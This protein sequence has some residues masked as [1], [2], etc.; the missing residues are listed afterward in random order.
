[1]EEEAVKNNPVL[2]ILIEFFK[3]VYHGDE[4]KVVGAINVIA[5]QVQQEGCKLIHFGNVVFLVHVTGSHMVEFHAMVGGKTNEKQK[6]AEIDKQL[7]KLLPMLKELGV[8]IAYTTMPKD[9]VSKFAHILDN[10]KFSKR[11][12][13][14]PDGRPGVA[15]Y[16]SLEK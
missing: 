7:D 15:F 2:K 8:L 5:D 1:M 10:Y 9:K 6:L 11:D 12:V 16:V 14:L 3:D 4:K 13:Q